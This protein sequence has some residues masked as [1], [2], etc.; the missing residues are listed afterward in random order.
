MLLGS[1]ARAD[2]L[3]K[4]LFL[5]DEPFMVKTI[6]IYMNPVERKYY[7][8]N[9]L[10]PKICVSKQTKDIYVKAFNMISEDEAKKMSENISCD[11][12]SNHK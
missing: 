3:A 8:F 4:C 2:D 7:P 5:N 6:I 11:C 1:L 12:K 9:V 10:S